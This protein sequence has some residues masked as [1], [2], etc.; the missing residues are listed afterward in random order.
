[1]YY[2]STQLTQRSKTTFSA[3][4]GA[5]SVTLSVCLG[6]IAH[7]SHFRLISPSRL[8][9]DFIMTSV[10]VSLSSIADLPQVSLKTVSSHN[11][12][13]HTV[14]AQSTFVLNRFTISRQFI[15]AG[16]HSIQLCQ[17]FI[18]F[19]SASVHS[20]ELSTF[21]TKLWTLASAAE[22]DSRCRLTRKL[23]SSICS[24]GI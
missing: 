6:Q 5:Q 20:A 4:T 1:M 9:N 15:L 24:S 10:R 17:R 23:N 21:T 7:S 22:L 3:P 8:Q 16:S 19:M 2:K 14:G 12:L 11:L 18:T 13:C